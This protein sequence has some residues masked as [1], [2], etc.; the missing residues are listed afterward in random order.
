MV[1]ANQLRYTLG[2]N[3]CELDMDTTSSLRQKQPQVITKIHI[4]NDKEKNPTP[5]YYSD[6]EEEFGD[7]LYRIKVVRALNKGELRI[8]KTHDLEFVRT[9]TEKT[10]V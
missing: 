3:T 9:E 4:T 1:E 2:M 10:N 6:T 7:K 5:E 8:G